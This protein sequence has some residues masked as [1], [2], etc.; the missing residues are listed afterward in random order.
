V[1]IEF[2]GVPKAGKTTTLGQVHAFLKRCGFRVEVVVEHAS[3]CPIRD[4]KHANFNAWTACTTLSEIL[5]KT[6]IPSRP[7]DPDVLILD[8]GLFDA[9][10]W[11]A[12]MER[13]ARIRK[14]E[15]ELIERF[16]LMDDWRKRITGVIVMTA[17]PTDSM[18]RERG[19]LPVNGAAGSIMNDDVLRTM[20]E[21]TRQ[22]AARLRK[23]HFR[24]FE[25]DTSRNASAGPR[26]TAEE[27]AGLVLGLI[28]EQLDEEILFLPEDTVAPLFE[29]A[30]WIGRA[31]AQQLVELFTT[32]GTFRSRET[33]ESDVTLVQALPVVVVRNRSGDLLQLKRKEQRKDNPLHGKIVI[34]AGGHVRREDGANGPSIG[35]GAVRELQEELRLSVE[36]RELELLGAVW[37][38]GRDGDR[39]RRHVAI[40]Y[41]WR[42]QTDDVAVALSATE[43]FERR[44]TSL[45]GSFVA[46]DQLATDIDDGRICEPW[47][48]EIARRLL[49]EGELVEPRLV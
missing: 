9:V 25:V 3:I 18:E 5:E 14:A 48:V 33:V 26:A 1:A 43:F 16:L 36:P 30:T 21:T 12:V 23:K 47:S 40:V 17:S 41:E 13:L 15:R 35:H 22:T 38:R 4:K 49:P 42:A 45:S 39:T 28:E 44:G 32:K 24:I 10:N 8:R 7:G 34:W 6:Q 20:L 31:A 11:F 19:Y 27:A 37:I 46:P 29:T 2:A